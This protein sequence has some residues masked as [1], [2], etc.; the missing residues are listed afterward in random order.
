V[1]FEWDDRKA[2]EN[3]KK[4]GVAFEDAA[5]VFDDEHAFTDVA[6]TVDEEQRF[7]TTGYAD[8]YALLTVIHT[9]RGDGDDLVVRIISARAASRRERREYGNHPPRT[10]STDP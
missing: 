10:Q 1:E 9:H 2:A 6:K 5:A 3:L 4:H 7:K 8:E